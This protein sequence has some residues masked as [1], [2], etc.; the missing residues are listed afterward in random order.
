M[1]FLEGGLN[2]G[3]FSVA[4]AVTGS[5]AST[6]VYDVTGAGIASAPAMIGAGGLNTA[7]GVDIGAGNGG[8]AE[9]Q[10][11]VTITAVTTVTGTL[12]IAVQCAPDNGAYSEGT[13]VTL[14][15]SAALTGATQ[16]FAGA[17]IVLDIPPVPPGFALP[18]FYRLYYTVGA[19]ISV[20]ASANLTTGAPT[21]KV[22]ARIGN[23]LPTL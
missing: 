11:L 16:L 22:A 15:S 17:Q 14:A 2:G 9:P 20:V 10:V 7:I 6:N 19:S 12:I 1:A 3:Q 23:N 8:L 4:Q 21:G 18:R 13:Y 5:A